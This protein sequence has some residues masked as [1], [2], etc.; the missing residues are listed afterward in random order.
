MCYKIIRLLLPLAILVFLIG[1]TSSAYKEEVE[2]VKIENENLYNEVQALKETMNKVT[3]SLDNLQFDLGIIR[4]E[5]MSRKTD[6]S[7]M[8]ETDTID[9]LVAQLR[10][11]EIDVAKASK[12]LSV[13]GKSAIIALVRQL[14]DTDIDIIKRVETVLALMQPTDVVP[15]LSENL[16]QKEIRNSAARVLGNTNDPSAVIPL[17]EQIKD[18]DVDFVFT[19]AEALVRL[20]DKRGIPVLID[21][22]KS[23]NPSRR[24]LAFDTLSKV[25]GLNFN[26]KPYLSDEERTKA[27]TEWETWWLKEGERFEFK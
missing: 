20:K 3:K 6:N 21:S 1:C 17:A 15:V 7:P 12:E 27:V 23:E 24:A 14:K 9:K 2:R 13:Y 11:N 26:Y 25:T 18:K 16:K 4:K 8:G 19:V 5:L 10:N 22:L